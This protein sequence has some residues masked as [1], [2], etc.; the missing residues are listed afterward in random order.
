VELNA[1]TGLPYKVVGKDKGKQTWIVFHTYPLVMTVGLHLKA[2]RK[3]ES[4]SE[5]LKTLI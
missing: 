2:N 5:P 4:F 1:G 3:S